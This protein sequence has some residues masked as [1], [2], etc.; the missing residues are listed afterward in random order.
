MLLDPCMKRTEKS[1]K[2]T[3]LQTTLDQ[4]GY[5]WGNTQVLWNAPH[6]SWCCTLYFHDARCH[7]SFLLRLRLLWKQEVQQ[8]RPSVASKTGFLWRIVETVGWYIYIIIYIYAS[9]FVFALVREYRSI[10]TYQDIRTPD[11]GHR[12][13][14]GSKSHFVAGQLGN[15]IS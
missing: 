4:T 5:S 9:V 2:S 3:I 11:A 7:Q 10:W 15:L 12:L 14:M 8:K 1:L 13:D 6:P